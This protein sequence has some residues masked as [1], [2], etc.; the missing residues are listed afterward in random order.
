MAPQHALPMSEIEKKFIFTFSNQPCE[1]L[2]EALEVY[3]RR[4]IEDASNIAKLERSNVIRR[5]HVLLA[6][7]L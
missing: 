1:N 5:R 2:E 6:L 7:R 3:L 4:V